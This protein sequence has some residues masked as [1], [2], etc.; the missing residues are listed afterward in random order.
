[1]AEDVLATLSR[2]DDAASAVGT[3]NAPGAAGAKPGGSDPLNL[4]TTSGFGLES[5]AFSICAVPLS[6]APLYQASAPFTARQLCRMGWIFA[7][8]AKG[9]LKTPF[10]VEMVRLFE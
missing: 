3:E 1:V 9:W 6:K 2:D 8:P 5:F 7:L 4:R 10:A